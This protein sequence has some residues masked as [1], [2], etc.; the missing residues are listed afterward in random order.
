MKTSVA[1]RANTTT[2][3]FLRPRKDRYDCVKGHDFQTRARAMLSLTMMCLVNLLKRMR[4]T[5]AD[6][7]AH[8]SVTHL[9]V[10]HSLRWWSFDD[11]SSDYPAEFTIPHVDQPG[12]KFTTVGVMH[13]DVEDLVWWMDKCFISLSS[14][15]GFD[16]G[17]GSCTIAA[18]RQQFRQWRIQ[19]RPDLELRSDI[20]NY[21][22][23]PISPAFT[24]SYSLKI[25]EFRW[26][27]K[28]TI[29]KPIGLP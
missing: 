1:R 27:T 25:R 2:G 10:T 4:V 14:V 15:F 7:A 16:I 23:I 24:R 6:L 28:P 21:R 3:S 26:T 18:F 11:L 13:V 8:H 5:S 19:P 29:K 22:L 12:H 17:A 9:S 20:L